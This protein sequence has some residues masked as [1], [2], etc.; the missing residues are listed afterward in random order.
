[1]A[2]FVD[3]KTASQR[4]RRN[5]MDKGYRRVFSIQRERLYKLILKGTYNGAD[6]HCTEVSLQGKML[7][8]YFMSGLNKYISALCKYFPF[9]VKPQ[10]MS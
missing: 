10:V 5:K 2:L 9:Y 7:H 1:M 8:R 3:V 4:K 6:I